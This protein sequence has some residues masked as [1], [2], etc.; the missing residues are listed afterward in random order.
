MVRTFLFC[1]A[2]LSAGFLAAQSVSGRVTDALTGEP[3]WGV[4]VYFDGSTTGTLTNEAGEFALQP[5]FRTLSTLVFSHI[6][7]QTRKITDPYAVDFLEITLEEDVQQLSEVVLPSDPFSRR[8][9]LQAF[10]E[11]FLG[12]GRAGRQCEILNEDAVRLFFNTTDS[13]L[14]ATAS[15][16]LQIR[17][18]YLGYSIRFD[19]QEFRVAFRSRSLVRTDNIK[20]TEFRGSS[21]FTDISGGDAKIAKRRA[22]AY[23]GSPMHFMRSLYRGRLFEESFLL[24]DDGGTLTSR[25]LAGVS[26]PDAN[27]QVTAAFRPDRFTVYYRDDFF[28]RSSI[29]VTDPKILRID[30][31]GTFAPYSVLIFDGE[32]ALHRMGLMLPTDYGILDVDPRGML[33]EAANLT[34]AEP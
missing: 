32:M 17:N 20:T 19:L 26:Q 18:P 27:R 15:E 14:N 30:A 31:F 8:Q 7:Y 1:L 13:T 6:G 10:R 22:D 16:P 11:E 3:V 29:R 4:S 5:K 24:R 25:D 21:R 12:D 28:R 23:Q 33:S 34:R 9:K 2:F